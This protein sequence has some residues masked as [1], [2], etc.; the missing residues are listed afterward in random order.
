MAQGVTQISLA[1]QILQRLASLG[2]AEFCVCAGSRNAPFVELLNRV[3]GVKVW[4]SFEER[5]VAFFAT[6][7]ISQTGKPVAVITTSGT[8]VAEVLPATIEAFHSGLPLVIISCDRPQRFIGTGAPQTI[9][10]AHLLQSF[11]S[12]CELEATPASM[13]RLHALSFEAHKPLHLNVHLDEPLIDSDLPEQWQLTPSVPPVTPAIPSENVQQALQ[14]IR[15]SQKPLLY[16]GPMKPAEAAHVLEHVQHLK[17]P[18]WAE[19][20]SQLREKISNIPLGEQGVKTLDWD[21]LIRVGGVPT[22][23]IWRDL[24]TN[25]RPVISLASTPKWPGLSRAHPVLNLRDL[26]KVVPEL[27][28][29]DVPPKMP[30]IHP[31]L[32][33]FERY[34]LAEPSWIRRLSL[35]IP[36][37]SQVY[38]GNSLPIREWDWAAATD[39]PFVYGFNRGANGIDGQISSFLG[40]SQP[41]CENWAVIGDLTAL[42]DLASLW[43]VPQMTERALRLVVVNNGGGQI[44]SH[45]YKSEAF[46]NEHNLHF[47]G[48]AQLW[49]WEYLRWEDARSLPSDLSSRQVI[50]IVVDKNQTQSFYQELKQL[51]LKEG[52][53]HG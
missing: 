23:R 49:N 30:H 6:G 46:R 8:A 4:W 47:A 3:Q 25:N 37:H 20:C 36:E 48:L 42:Y 5:S 22:A 7:R 35:A 11:A 26:N 40:W 45:L 53:T 16:L 9:T 32:A 27:Q 52:K 29:K 28:N 34:P 41:N 19:A 51:R 18:I 1:Q 10:Q 14:M 31:V 15:Q 50:E 13:E 38:L 44:F 12:L 21:L 24:E 39:K 33:L 43:V 2:V 17:I